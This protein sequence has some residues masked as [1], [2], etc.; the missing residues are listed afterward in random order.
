MCILDLKNVH[1]SF[2]SK[3]VLKGIGLQVKQGDV[4]GLLGRNGAGKTTLLK[5]VMGLL[6]PHKGEIEVFGLDPRKKPVEVKQR[7]GY[8]A[9]SQALPQFLKVKEVL[10]L[11]R[12][13]Y[14]KWDVKFAHDLASRFELP[15]S[16]K[17]KDLSRGQARQVALLCAVSHRPELLILDEP[18]GGLDPAAR[19]DFLETSIE[20][21]NEEGTTIIFSSH[22]MTDVERMANRLVMVHENEKWIDSDLD[23]IREGYCL[24]QIPNDQK[25]E[26][27]KILGNSNCIC[28]HQRGPVLHAV[29]ELDPESCQRTLTNEFKI[30]NSQCRTINLEEMFIELVRRSS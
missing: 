7:I 19:R 27:E 25:F 5:L 30:E 13:L 2:G 3:E 4:V 15:S 10:E 6:A 12:G 20:L 26:S 22:H 9:E 21:L 17:I 1:R 28:V 11:Y 16:G 23:D 18:A 24:A 29:F 14:P 8:V